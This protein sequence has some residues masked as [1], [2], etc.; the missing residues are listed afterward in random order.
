MGPHSKTFFFI[1]YEW[2]KKARMFAPVRP[3]R[4]V[5]G[6]KAWSLPYGARERCS[7]RVDSG[8]NHKHYIM[9]ERLATDK[10]SI[11][12]GPFVSWEEKKFC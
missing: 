6:G 9:L 1:T 3:F 2:S 7:T 11:L 8:L 5:F 12:F 4:P 10:H